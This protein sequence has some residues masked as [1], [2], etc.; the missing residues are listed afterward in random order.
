MHKSS[1]EARVF[2][3]ALGRSPFAEAGRVNRFDVP[4]HPSIAIVASLLARTLIALI[5]V[6]DTINVSMRPT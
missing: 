5:C 1:A 4:A 6:G 2:A 3:E